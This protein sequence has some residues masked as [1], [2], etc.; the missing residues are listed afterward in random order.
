MTN[1]PVVIFTAGVFDILHYGH[2]NY[3][4]KAKELGDILVVGLLTDNGTE[5][6]KHKPIM[7]KGERLEVLVAVKYIDHIFFQDNTDP[8]DILYYIWNYD[9]DLF[10]DIL[11]RASDVKEPVPG[12]EYIESKGGKVVIVDYTEG[13][14]S[15]II[16]ERIINADR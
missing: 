1:K 13:I 8:T 3:L 12:Q 6:Y 2:I 15:S 10:P 14:S 9:R 11:V 7:S 4:R 5:K 16:K